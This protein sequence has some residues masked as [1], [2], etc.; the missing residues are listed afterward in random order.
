MS[1]R[2][3][4]GDR[5]DTG[6]GGA[7][8]SPIPQATVVNCALAEQSGRVAFYVDLDDT[9]WSTLAV[10]NRKVAEIIVEACKLDD[11]DTYGTVDL[12]KLDLEG[13]EL[14]ALKGGCNLIS[15]DR[16]IIM[17]ESGPAEFMGYTK[18]EMYDWLTTRD[19]RIFLPARLGKEAPA[20]SE[21]VYLDSHHYPFGTLN[22]FAVPA[23]RIDE[24]ARRIAALGT[25]SGPG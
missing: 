16:P 2:D 3:C 23:E 10:N 18:V 19:Y 20:M 8:W 5:G 4:R 7:P 6:K 25:P 1:W 11:F 17:Y 15:R 13:A 9:A 14:G 22:Y 21:E 12:L 24:I